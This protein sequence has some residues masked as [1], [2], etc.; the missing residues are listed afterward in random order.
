MQFENRSEYTPRLYSA[1]LLGQ[2][3][4]PAD[5]WSARVHMPHSGCGI[6]PSHSN[7]FEAS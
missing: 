1:Q 7:G 3:A 4:F 6:S 2:S 5:R